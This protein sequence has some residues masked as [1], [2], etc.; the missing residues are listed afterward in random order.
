MFKFKSCVAID[1][2]HGHLP[3]SGKIK[4]RRLARPVG[5]VLCGSEA[6]DRA[7]ASLSAAAF[8]SVGAVLKRL[9][10]IRL[11]CTLAKKTAQRHGT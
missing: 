2:T 8:P 10:W 3:S 7:R 6:W 1:A 4:Q 5:T 11:E 9:I